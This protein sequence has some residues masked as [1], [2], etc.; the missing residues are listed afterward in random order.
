MCG[1]L[2]VF[3]L[4]QVVGTLPGYI[5]RSSVGCES[6]RDYHYHET[7]Y[8]PGCISDMAIG[9]SKWTIFF[10][11]GVCSQYSPF[12]VVTANE[13]CLLGKQRF[14]LRLYISFSPLPQLAHM[15]SL[16]VPIGTD[17]IICC[18]CYCLIESVNTPLPFYTKLIHL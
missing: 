6:Y 10:S 13:I 18:C 8:P 12:C 3:D 1:G 7:E 4:V 15:K 14:S 5:L 11:C 9:G 17:D 2:I 16:S